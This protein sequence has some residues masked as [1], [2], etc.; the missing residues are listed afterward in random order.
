M[1][2]RLVPKHWSKSGEARETD[3]SSDDLETS[4]LVSAAPV[5]VAIL[6]DFELQIA[7]FKVV[8]HVRTLESTATKNAA[9]PHELLGTLREPW[10]LTLDVSDYVVLL[11]DFELRQLRMQSCKAPPAE[12][13]AV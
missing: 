11:A 2:N 12:R 13:L 5:F 9:A 10:E 1:P 8:K 7:I 4:V 6:V 3:I